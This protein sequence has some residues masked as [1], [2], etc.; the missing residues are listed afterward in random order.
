MKHHVALPHSKTIDHTRVCN[1][2][3]HLKNEVDATVAVTGCSDAENRDAKMAITLISKRS[4]Y[5]K[6]FS[7]D[8]SGQFEPITLMQDGSTLSRS[9]GTIVDEDENI[10]VILN[11]L[12]MPIS[13]ITRFI[14]HWPPP[15]RMFG[16]FHMFQT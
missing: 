8:F 6:S 13:L 11:L 10:D 9:G 7:M 5:Q 12:N 3:G 2:L 16:V 1:Y 14:Q 4:P 15:F